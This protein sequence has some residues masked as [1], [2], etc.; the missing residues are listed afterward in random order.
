V[1]KNAIHYSQN[2]KTIEL[3]PLNTIL[4]RGE[5]NLMNVLAA[6]AIASVAGIAPDAIRLGVEGFAG[7]PH[8][9]ELVRELRGARWYNDSIATAPERTA[10][11]IRSFSEPIV[12]LL[13]GR[14]KDLPWE[15]LVRLIHKR[16]R[17]V[18]LF[19]ELAAKVGPLLESVQT[20]GNL[21]DI[22]RCAS[23]EEAVDLANRKANSGEVVLFSPGGTSF[24]A[25][26]DFE[27]RGEDFKKWVNQLS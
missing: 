13:G 27:E 1:E 26:K 24:D 11:A 4:L 8:R 22:S 9:L 19:G 15:E 10:A 20:G 14:D 18:V 2:G 12:L 25:Y 17:A 3:L 21:T 7:V 5:H 23:V 6:C 16:V